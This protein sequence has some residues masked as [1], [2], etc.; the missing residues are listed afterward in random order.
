M[1]LLDHPALGSNPRYTRWMLGLL[2]LLVLVVFTE[3][4]LRTQAP[5]YTLPPRLI[6]VVDLVS[7][8]AIFL[9]AVA[10]VFGVAYGAVNGGPLLAAVVVL[11][12]MMAGTVVSR[13]LTLTVDF[14]VALAGVAAAAGVGA[15]RSPPS[16]PV[17]VAVALGALIPAL[18]FT[19]Q[20]PSTRARWAILGLAVI[21]VFSLGWIGWQHVRQN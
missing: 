12:P 10:I 7:A 21:S 2:G 15:A 5:V 1:K 3:R 13:E 18:V 6:V 11:T 8:A 9:V 19:L 14:V 16:A 17:G 4:I 20:L